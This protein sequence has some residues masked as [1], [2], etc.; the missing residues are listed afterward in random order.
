MHSIGRVYHWSLNS[1]ISDGLKVYQWTAPK[2]T[3]GVRHRRLISPLFFNS[4]IDEVMENSLGSLH[5]V[6]IEVGSR[7]KLCDLDSVDE[8]VYLFRWT[9]YA[10]RAGDRLVRVLGP[11]RMC[12]IPSN[13]EVLLESWVWYSRK[14]LAIVGRI[15]SRGSYPTNNDTTLVE[16]ECAHTWGLNGFPWAK[17]LAAPNRCFIGIERSCTATQ[18]I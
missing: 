17:A 12:F 4:I 6:G 1:N 8:L 10:P 11:L 14:N 16:S 13:C 5:Y 15:S 3:S 2:T 7:A 18:R 9:E